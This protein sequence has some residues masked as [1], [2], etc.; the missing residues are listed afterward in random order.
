M[1]PEIDFDP[2][3][4]GNPVPPPHVLSLQYV[5]LIVLLRDFCSPHSMVY[6]TLVTLLHR[7]FVETAVS[8]STDPHTVSLCWS[9]CEEAA[10]GTTA[11]LE[12]YRAAFSLARAPYLIVSDSTLDSVSLTNQ[13]YATFVAATIHVR[14]AAQ[15]TRSSE[16]NHLL[17][18]CIEGLGENSATNPGVMKMYQ[19][20]S[21][22]MTKLGITPIADGNQTTPTVEVRDNHSDQTQGQLNDGL[23]LDAIIR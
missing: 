16:A 5:L 14:I 9:R 17:Q 19:S 23:D 10:R 6:Y 8:T 22:L 4:T 20:I 12:R 3:A 1:P 15:R 2:F 13:S 18:S 11:L 21:G 7:P